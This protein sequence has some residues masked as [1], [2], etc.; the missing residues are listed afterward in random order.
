M[1]IA[2]IGLTGIQGKNGD[3]G[4]EDGFELLLG[5]SMTGE[6]SVNRRTGVKLL[7]D[8]VAPFLTRV[9]AF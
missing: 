8:Q 4:T 5:G 2:D 1:R 7:K 6:L 3:H 9:L